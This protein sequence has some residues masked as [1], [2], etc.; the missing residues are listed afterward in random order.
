MGTVCAM[1]HSLPLSALAGGS[2]LLVLSGSAFAS[3][4]PEFSLGLAGAMSLGSVQDRSEAS[5][6]AADARVEPAVSA[7]FGTKGS[8]WWSVSASG[9]VDD[10]AAN[11]DYSLR[12]TYHRF[13]AE[14]FE[15]NL[16]LT[17][18]FHDQDVD[19]EAS[20]SFDL[21]FR[22][23]FLSDRDRG[24]SVYGDIGIGF[25][26]SSGPVPE[27][28]TDYNFTPRAGVGVTLELPDQLGGDIGARLDL[29]VGWQHYSNASTSGSDENP[30]RDSIYVR[31]GVIFPF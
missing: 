15:L 5:A 9:M 18:W 11:K 1:I 14:D 7:T 27:D 31:A 23:H 13:L 20:G 2:A 25:M 28:G 24:W 10:D 29:G 30:G 16:A 22:Y 4:A 12:F 21:G 3:P 8:T 17:G 26:L 19:D 6:D